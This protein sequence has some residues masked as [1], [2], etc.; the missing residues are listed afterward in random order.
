[1]RGP[2]G[3]SGT[4]Q[5]TLEEDRDESAD[6]L[7]KVR[8]GSEDSRD[9][10]GWVRGLLRRTGTSRR[11]H[12]VVRDGSEDSRGGPGRVG[13]PFRRSGMGQGTLGRSNISDI[14]LGQVRD[15]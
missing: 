15:E 11:T 12:S 3:R 5:R 8:D 9:G 4:G 14:T 7:G 2:L 13:G 10:P 6:P 1:M